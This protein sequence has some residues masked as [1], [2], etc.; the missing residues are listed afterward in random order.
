M[1]GNIKGDL[2]IYTQTHVKG[3]Q[4]GRGVVVPVQCLDRPAGLG[5]VKPMFLQVDGPEKV[6]MEWDNKMRRDQDCERHMEEEEEE[7]RCSVDWMNEGH[8][9]SLLG[10]STIVPPALSALGAEPP[11]QNDPP[12][13]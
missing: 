13:R 4:P 6:Q 9:V 1:A 7:D 3:V 11:T 12:W 2:N 8:L 5:S 10:A